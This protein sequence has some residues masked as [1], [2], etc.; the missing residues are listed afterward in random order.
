MGQHYK[1]VLCEQF[2]K[3]IPILRKPSVLPG[4]KTPATN[5]LCEITTIRSGNTEHNYHQHASRDMGLCHTNATSSHPMSGS[6]LNACQVYIIMHTN[7]LWDGWSSSVQRLWVDTCSLYGLLCLLRSYILATSKAMSGWA[8][9]VR[10]VH[11]GR[12][13][14]VAS[15]WD[16]TASI[17]TAYNFSYLYNS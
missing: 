16:Q 14:S 15:V 11:W 2:H 7:G 3:S 10:C 5:Q 6:L 1:V 9:W 4:G 17:M 13:H 8:P 12:L